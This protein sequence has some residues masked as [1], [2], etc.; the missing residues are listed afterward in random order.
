M[1]TRNVRLKQRGDFAFGRR[2]ILISQNTIARRGQ[3]NVRVKAGIEKSDCD[4][5]ARKTLIGIEPQGSRKN[6]R[7]VLGHRRLAEDLV[8]GAREQLVAARADDLEILLVGGR[9]GA[10]QI[11]QIFRRG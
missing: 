10:N 3:I 2:H 1:P 7:P 9:V 11:L 8:F 6:V 4:I 5:F